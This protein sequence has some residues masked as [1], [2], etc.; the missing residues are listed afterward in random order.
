MHGSIQQL[1]D[2]VDERGCLKKKRGLQRGSELILDYSANRYPLPCCTY[3]SG[4][5]QCIA[6]LGSSLGNIDGLHLRRMRQAVG[7]SGC[8]RRGRDALAL[9]DIIYIEHNSA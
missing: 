2:E 9:I 3:W 7:V 8:V 6:Q 5:V 1:R 4:L